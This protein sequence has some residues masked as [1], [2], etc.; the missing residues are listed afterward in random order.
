MNL[1][2]ELTEINDVIW[3]KQLVDMKKKNIYIC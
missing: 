1:N 2:R 3:K